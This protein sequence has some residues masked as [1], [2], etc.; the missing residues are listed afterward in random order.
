[1]PIICPEGD[2]YMADMTT[3][4]STWCSLFSEKNTKDTMQMLIYKAA[5]AYTVT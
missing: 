2:L 1:M 4:T 3:T 5:S